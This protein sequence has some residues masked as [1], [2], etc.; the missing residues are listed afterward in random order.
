MA[1]VCKA[2]GANVAEPAD[3]LGHDHRIGRPGMRPF[4]GFITR[5]D[6]LGTG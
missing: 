3:V 6:E 2:A 1:E 5:A 4:A